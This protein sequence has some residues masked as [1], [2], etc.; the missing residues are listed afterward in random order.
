M[1]SPIPEPNLNTNSTDLDQFPPL[2][3]QETDHS[4]DV[5][6]EVRYGSGKQPGW[7]KYWPYVLVVWALWFAFFGGAGLFHVEQP[8]NLFFSGIIIV[9]AI[10]HLLAS[11]FKWPNLPLG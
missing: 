6:G 11:R 1:A 8:I 7:M 9:W 2:P 3:R 4:E 5:A 10:Y